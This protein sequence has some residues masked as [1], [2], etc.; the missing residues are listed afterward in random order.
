MRVWVFSD[1]HIDINKDFAL[2]RERPDHDVVVIAGDIREN[3]EKSVRW[4]A[5]RVFDRPVVFVMGNHEHYRRAIDTNTQNAREAAAE[6]PHIHLLENN[7]VTI[8]GVRFIGATLWTD[9]KLYGSEVEFGGMQLAEKSMNDHRLIRIAA[10]GYG[11]F[12]P[13]HALLHHEQSRDFVSTELAAC[14]AGTKKVV[15]T[16]HCPSAKSIAPQYEGQLLNAAYQSNLDDLAAQADLWVHGH[17]HLN[18]DY[19]IGDARILCN[20]HGYGRENPDFNPS[21]VV[22]V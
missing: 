8:N 7:A 20:P 12:L 4:I 9:Y 18:F 22:E 14:D 17:V 5:D 2:P 16:H 1:L 10:S 21:M 3:A 19:R 13:K 11:R 15:V 6:Y